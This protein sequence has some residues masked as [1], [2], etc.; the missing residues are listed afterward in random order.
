[1]KSTSRAV[2]TEKAQACD[3]IGLVLLY[4]SANAAI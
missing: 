1:M 2:A 4:F 3:G